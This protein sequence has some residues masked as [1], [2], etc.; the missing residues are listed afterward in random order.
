M[1]AGFIGNNICKS[2]SY[3]DSRLPSLET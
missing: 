3:Q 2:N 1:I